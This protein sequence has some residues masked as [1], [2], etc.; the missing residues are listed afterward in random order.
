MAS[1]DEPA[2]NGPQEGNFPLRSRGGPVKQEGEEAEEVGVPSPGLISL[3]NSGDAKAELRAIYWSF[4]S[5]LRP[6][7]HSKLEMIFQLSVEQFLR[8]MPS[9]ERAVW[10]EKWESS[11][12]NMEAFMGHLMNE[13]P[14]PPR[15]VLAQRSA[16]ASMALTL[17]TPSQTPPETPRPTAPGDADEDGENLSNPDHQPLEDESPH[18]PAESEGSG[19][20][21]RSSR[22]ASSGAP[23]AQGEPPREEAPREVGGARKLC[24]YRCDQ[25]PRV[26]RCL[27][28]FQLHQMRHNNERPFACAKCGKRFFQASDLR[29][30]ELTHEKGGPFPCGR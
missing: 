21:L 27:F 9:S 20:S 24:L 6:D 28:R 16:A 25:C 22:S 10:R 15:M 2:R 19:E 8:N 7:R 5:W 13:C 11:G 14:R 12:R 4:W 30:H 17:G 26:F 23:T 3:N 29:V 18:G 1:Q